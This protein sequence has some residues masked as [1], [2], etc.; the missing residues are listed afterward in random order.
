MQTYVSGSPGSCEQVLT[1]STSQ[2]ETAYALVDGNFEPPAPQIK[3]PSLRYWR[4]LRNG[5]RR[6]GLTREYRDYLASLPRP[7]RVA[8]T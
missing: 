5:A 8:E 7:L 1:Y 4:L 2:R 6:H 3:L